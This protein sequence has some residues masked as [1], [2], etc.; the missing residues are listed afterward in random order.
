MLGQNEE[1]IGDVEET[2]NF[3]EISEGRKELRK[4]IKELG[5]KGTVFEKNYKKPLA[6]A[7]ERAS[8]FK[9]AD[10]KDRENPD[11]RDHGLKGAKEALRKQKTEYDEGVLEDL[12]DRAHIDYEAI[13]QATPEVGEIQKVMEKISADKDFQMR[14]MFENSNSRTRESIKKR[15]E[16]VLKS[17]SEEIHDGEEKLNKANPVVLRQAE[18]IEY[19]EN[20]AQSGHICITPSTEED[21][22]FIGKKMLSGEPMLLYGPTGTGKTSLAKYASE[23]FTGKRARVVACSNQTKESNIY[24]KTSV[25]PAG[26]SGAME[27]YVDYGPLIKA[28]QEG[29][30]VVFDEFNTLDPGLLVVLK[31]VFA[32]RIGDPL[33]VPGN[34]TIILQPGF[35]AIFTANLKSEKNPERQDITPEI[36]REFDVNSRKVKY[37]PS[38]EAYDI[39]LSRLLNKDGS[40]DMSYYDLNTTLPNLVKVMAE[41][42]QSYTNETDKDVARRA[43]A[44]DASGK[45]YSLKKMVVTQGTIQKILSLWTVEKR[46][47]EKKSFSEFLDQ[48]FK[49]MLFKPLNIIDS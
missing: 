32:T 4:A 21:L 14:R 42:Q 37:T 13:L 12:E 17:I 33:D 18:L 1:P 43:G 47:G 23:H 44:M 48:N 39:I 16:G 19:K 29:C 30:P 28:A 3:H 15:N 24:G 36:L 46:M 35:Q 40:L 5:D 27:T 10:F 31:N 2:P 7:N 22:M 11:E 26:D 38:D 34:G 45:V 20:L 25:R 6:E 41:I 9:V 49:S 8:S